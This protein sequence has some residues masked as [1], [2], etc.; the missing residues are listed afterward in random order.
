MQR[1]N[2][3]K[4]YQLP[5]AGRPENEVKSLPSPSQVG[6]VPMWI[7]HIKPRL[8]VS[9]GDRVKIGAALFED[10]RN[11][12]IH[13]SSPAAG[14]VSSIRFG[15]RRVIQAIVID[16]EQ[17]EEPAVPFD[18]ISADAIGGMR[19]S[20]L[21]NQILTGGLWWTLGQLPFRDMPDPEAVP[22]AILV[23]LSAKE[24]FQASP[25]VYLSDSMDLFAYGLKVLRR[26]AD[27][28]VVVYADAGDT[29]TLRLCDQWLT[30]TIKGRYPADDPGTVNY[31]LKQSADQNRAW[32]MTGQ[33]VLLLARFLSQGR[34][35]TERIIA[36]GGPAAP[37]PK[38]LRTRL[39]V[40]LAH[41]LEAAEA[42]GKRLVV[43]GCMRGFAA[44]ADGFMG[45]RQTSLTVLD[46]GREAEFLALFNPGLKKPTYSRTFLSALNSGLLHY[47]CNLNGDRRAC[48][49]CMHCAD[50]CPVNILPQMAHKA[51]LAEAV[52]EYLAHGLL[53]CVD[54]GL[55]SYV[56]PSKIELSQT[57]KET[58]AAF[59]KEQQSASN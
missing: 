45:L 47:D 59:A 30:H 21:V 34:Y 16:C 39:G 57:F 52:E 37:G 25:S 31:H 15:P 19:R 13:F 51:I 55:C 14:T 12:A 29:E 6:L 9:E 20:D 10:K 32:Y 43:G 48:I 4:G 40:P 46:E 5:M 42:G 17:G 54:C 38:H 53:D 26:L 7:P 23:S 8:N 56:C 33:D 22:P 44:G 3:K 11:P 41:L 28:K 24:P 35:P 36:L 27:D 1:L 50:V 49:G 2:I 58:R 18:V